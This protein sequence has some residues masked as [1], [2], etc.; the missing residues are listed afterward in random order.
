MLRPGT[1]SKAALSSEG[2]SGTCTERFEHQ[3]TSSALCW[4][5]NVTTG[6]QEV[7]QVSRCSRRSPN[8]TS[9]SQQGQAGGCCLLV[10][11]IFVFPAK[12]GP[13]CGCAL[14]HSFS[15][16]PGKQSYWALPW[17]FVSPPSTGLALCSVQPG[18][19]IPG[20][21]LTHGQGWVK[22]GELEKICLTTLL[23][24]RA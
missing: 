19:G 17:S 10:L 3:G 23:L 1:M 22:E 14:L 6:P 18:R 8:P 20:R 12:P 13:G 7:I 11:H 24:Y 15:R 5:S 4:L 2:R 16:T 9:W 21:S